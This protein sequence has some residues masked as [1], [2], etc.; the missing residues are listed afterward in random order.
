MV[1]LND[2]LVRLNEGKQV[3]TVY[4]FTNVRSAIKILEDDILL[5]ERSNSILNKL[6]K[7]R[8]RGVTM[9]QWKR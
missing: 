2:I 4:H 3:G 1:N 9:C 5:A 7:S 8:I 6:V